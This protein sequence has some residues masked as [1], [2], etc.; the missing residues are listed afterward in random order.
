MYYNHFMANV[1]FQTGRPW[2]TPAEIA[3]IERTLVSLPEPVRVLEYGCG[4]SSVYFSRF[5]QRRGKSYVWESVESNREWAEKV[6]RSCR[7]Y[8]LRHTNI[9]L[10]DFGGMRPGKDDFPSQLRDEYVAH[11]DRRN[12][13]YGLVI[14]DGRFRRRCLEYVSQRA[15][16]GLILLHDAERG[17]YKCSSYAGKSFMLDTG[18]Q[19]F[20]VEPR[21]KKLFVAACSDESWRFLRQCVLEELD[22]QSINSKSARLH[23]AYMKRGYRVLRKSTSYVRMFSQHP[24]SSIRKVSVKLR[25]LKHNRVARLSEL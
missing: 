4:Y 23:A 13:D 7:R 5:L 17:R 11:F 25:T 1:G 16:D 12:N 2:M 22:L 8:G 15:S 9:S 18:I 6:R 10:V 20:K 3:F 14:I 21:D 19:P 24:V